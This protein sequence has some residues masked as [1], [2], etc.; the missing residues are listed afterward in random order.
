MTQRATVSQLPAAVTV[1]G[2]SQP[3]W[4]R[5][6]FV[7][8]A[9][10]VIALAAAYVVKALA[11]G[12][13]IAQ[14]YEA[15]VGRNVPVPGS[16]STGSKEGWGL[17]RYGRYG[18]TSVPD[19]HTVKE[20]VVFLWGD[21]FVLGLDLPDREKIAQQA[22]QLLT[23]RHDRQG[24]VAGV[25]RPYWSVADYIQYMPKYESVV[26]SPAGHI[27]H[28]FTLLDTF[29]D[30]PPADRVSQF[31]SVPGGYEMEFF[32]VE[33][34]QKSPPAH[35]SETM[36][37]AGT[38]RANLLLDSLRS[39]RS[40]RKELVGLVQHPER[41]LRREPDHIASATPSFQ[42]EPLTATLET[43]LE[44][45]HYLLG[46]LRQASRHP[47]T[48]IYAPAVPLPVG[49]SIETVNQEEAQVTAFHALCEQHGIGFVSVEPAFQSLYKEKKI[50]PRGFASGKFGRGHY[51]RAG[52]REVAAA[53]AVS[54]AVQIDALHP[55]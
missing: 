53:V 7:W 45:W 14:L 55:D 11:P 38:L 37:L 1:P 2:P 28:L 5:L 17:T 35:L 43:P 16:W 51:N 30:Q 32:D 33:G 50:L 19:L 40:G 49:A 20:P 34:G 21:S 24:I 36:R 8:G 4:C 47:I 46:R 15:E 22:T 54:S 10:L 29:P 39:V 41:L 52:A 48:I 44:A 9:G 13:N 6:A 25:G 27:I 26:T 12:G 23:F 31:K 3:T 18:V 42:P